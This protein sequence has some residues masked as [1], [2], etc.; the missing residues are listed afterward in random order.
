MDDLDYLLPIG[1]VV[2]LKDIDKQEVMIY[3]RKQKR[4]NE[5]KIWDY[6]GC[7]YPQGN[8]SKDYNIFFDHNQ[9]L[10]VIFKGY[11]TESEIQLRRKLVEL[12]LE[13]N[14]HSN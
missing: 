14:K 4:E 9:I 5:S 11:E 1:S 2:Y 3:G 7:P 13:L 12:H 10:K 8:I 6:V